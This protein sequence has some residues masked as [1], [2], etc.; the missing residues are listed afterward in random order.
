[1]SHSSDCHTAIVR[2]TRQ[3]QGTASRW[4][5]YA[6]G[7]TAAIVLLLTLWPDSTL[8][9]ANFVPLEQ[10]GAALRC[11]L[12][13]C[14]TADDSASFLLVDVVGNVVVF[15]PIGFTLAGTLSARSV[16]RP[17][18]GA[19]VTGSL[20]S[21]AIETIQFQMAT[22]ATDI[23]DLLFNTLGTAIGAGLLIWLLSLRNLPDQVQELE[24]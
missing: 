14:P 18:W 10:H 3:G 5:P 21:F 16:K 24:R 13:G 17:F 6:A 7:L 22:R 12:A 19:V 15:V 2:R 23:D 11:V 4:W 8:N 20:L 9:S 1:M